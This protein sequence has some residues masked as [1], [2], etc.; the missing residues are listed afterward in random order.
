MTEY[1]V[2]ILKDVSTW[3]TTKKIVFLDEHFL[4]GI[5]KKLLASLDYTLIPDKEIPKI[6]YNQLFAL[7]AEIVDM[8]APEL[9]NLHGVSF[10]K[11][12]WDGLLYLYILEYLFSMYDKYLRIQWLWSYV[13]K[14]QVYINVVDRKKCL[15]SEDL[16]AYQLDIIGGEL[17]HSQMYSEIFLLDENRKNLRINEI[18]YNLYSKK[19]YILASN[20]EGNSFLKRAI[21]C[22]HNDSMEEI[23]RKI[24]RR[25]V[26]RFFYHKRSHDKVEG[27]A[28][29]LGGLGYNA[30]YRSKGR[31]IHCDFNWN[32]KIFDSNVNVLYRI[33]KSAIQ[34]SDKS[35]MSFS[36]IARILIFRDI[37][38]CYI[39][40][41]EEIRKKIPAEYRSPMLKFIGTTTWFCYTKLA[42]AAMEARERGVKLFGIQHGGNYG[43]VIYTG[44][45]EI[46]Q[47]DVFYSWG[48]WGRGCNKNVK[49]APTAKFLPY[50][51]IIKQGKGILYVGTILYS[52]KYMSVY[53]WNNG[54]RREYIARQI[55]I[56]KQ[57]KEE[58]IKDVTV[59][60]ILEEYG[61]NVRTILISEFPGLKIE[62][63]GKSYEK[64]FPSALCDCKLMIVDHL[65]TTWL[66]ALYANKPFIII[67]DEKD[68][69][70]RESE[71]KYINAMKRVGIM[72]GSEDAHIINDIYQDVDKWWNDAARQQVLKELRDRYLTNQYCSAT[73]LYDWWDKELNKWLNSEI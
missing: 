66:E 59:R 65:S 52:H 49:N 42:F 54:S 71:I 6:P 12:Y 35:I 30:I 34:K 38:K 33:K 56:L 26:K 8:L 1:F 48:D 31:M 22:I 3:D 40:D 61:W 67:V 29:G 55:K 51:G 62:G 20:T 39:E 14:G 43:V 13:D 19:E 28:V 53:P 16:A 37:P 57:L 10:S 63:A 64:D 58:I 46:T 18:D 50:K 5:D 27:I 72:I 69:D 73:E 44:I 2:P 45:Y 25:L 15:V 23:W 47:E 32:W 24:K 36:Q 70:W 68:I 11:K 60:Q 17:H 4:A 7:K 21:R 41:Y 9:N